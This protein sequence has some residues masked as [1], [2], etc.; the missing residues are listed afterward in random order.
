MHAQL[1]EYGLDN[2]GKLAVSYLAQMSLPE[3]PWLRED[4]SEYNNRAIVSAL[5]LAQ[6]L[7]R[8]GRISKEDY[9]T[10]VRQYLEQNR[11]N[12]RYTIEV[13][14]NPA[15]FHQVLDGYLPE[16]YLIPAVRE[17]SDETRAATASTLLVVSWQRS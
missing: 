3:D 12:V 2:A 10:A 4:F 5:P 15:G 6:H 1:F 13:R 9:A 8:A 14:R 17:V 16:L 7:P 11:G